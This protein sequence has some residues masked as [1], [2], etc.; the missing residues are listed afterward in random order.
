MNNTKITKP[1]VFFGEMPGSDGLL[2]HWNKLCEYYRLL[3]KES[4]KIKVVSP[5]KSSEGNEFLVIFVSSEENL[6]NLDK[7]SEIS[8]RVANDETLSDEEITRLSEEGR[9]IIHQDYSIHSNETGGAQSVPLTLYELLS[10][11]DG[12]ELCKALEETICIFTPCAEPDGLIRFHDFYYKYKGT[13]FEGFCS[14]H[15]RHILAGHCNNRDAIYERLCESRYLNDITIRNYNPQIFIAYHHQYPYD[16]RMSIGPTVNPVFEKFSGLMEFETSQCTTAM[17]TDLV[18]NGRKGITLGDP[19]FTSFPINTFHHH[20]RLHNIIGI[21]AENADVRIASP[22]YVHPDKLTVVKR[23]PTLE[24]PVPWEGGEWHLSDVVTNIKLGSLALIKHAAK[25]R[26]ELITNMAL[27]SRMQAERGRLDP[28]NTILVPENQNDSSTLDGFLRILHNQRIRVMRT[29]KPLTIGGVIYPEGT[30]AIPLAQPKYAAACLYADKTSHP[31]NEYTFESDGTPKISDTANLSV[32]FSMGIKTIPSYTEIPESDLAPFVYCEKKETL[33]FPLKGSENASYMEVNKALS[34]GKK[35][36]RDTEGNFYLEDGEGRCEIKFR[37]V[38]LYHKGNSTGSFEEGFTR[39]ILMTYGFDFITLDDKEIRDNGIPDDVE[40]IIFAGD[41]E[42]EIA[43]GDNPPERAPIEYQTGIGKKGLEELK[44][45][46]ARGGRAIAW[47]KACDYFNHSFNLALKDK[48]LRMS[49]KEYGTFGSLLRA[50]KENVPNDITLG[51]PQNFSVNSIFGTV[52]YPDDIV[53][54][55]EV[56]A[57][58]ETD[59]VLECGYI[60]G[61]EL[62]K[63]TPCIIRSRIS[64]GDIILY[65]FSPHFRFQQDGTFKLLFNALYKRCDEANEEVIPYV[66]HY[67]LG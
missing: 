67:E 25:N 45:F 62:I 2:I 30:Y 39:N 18:R 36:Y 12:S 17:A 15:V 4:K 7:Y 63:G 43:F 48:C 35:V 29:N 10:A 24:C 44:K 23:Y 46:F 31:V 51:M 56:L 27:K 20:A 49:P 40:A 66:A 50:K 21:L 1:E 64:R 47:E 13:R 34:V 53:H 3:E 6:K 11:E 8:R 61:E 22:I 38:G 65:T 16:P 19:R 26:R 14:P 58:F 28:K 33:S 42:N 32:A 37:K 57:S 60:R 5:G 9:A 41:K 54:R 55:C 52:L 59:N